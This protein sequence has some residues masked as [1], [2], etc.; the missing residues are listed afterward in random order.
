MTGTG[1]REQK[2][3]ER[4]EAVWAV[5]FYGSPGETPW[6][7]PSL[8]L[9]HPAVGETVTYPN[10]TKA[11]KNENSQPLVPIRL[12]PAGAQQTPRCRSLPT[13]IPAQSLVRLLRAPLLFQ[14]QPVRPFFFCVFSSSSSFVFHKASR[15]KAAS[16][17][18]TLLCTPP[19]RLASSLRKTFCFSS[20]LHS[21]MSFSGPVVAGVGLGCALVAAVIATFAVFAI[22]RDH[23]QGYIDRLLDRHRSDDGDGD[24]ISA[25]DSGE[26]ALVVAQIG[27]IYR[28]VWPLETELSRRYNSFRVALD[29]VVGHYRFSHKLD[30]P[31]TS[32]FDAVAGPHPDWE[33]FLEDDYTHRQ[34]PA[35]QHLICRILHQRMIPEGDPATTLLPPDIMSVYKK[36]MARDPRSFSATTYGSASNPRLE[37]LGRVMRHVWRGLTCHFAAYHA[38]HIIPENGL[39]D[40]DERMENVLATEKLLREEVLVHFRLST[41]KSRGQRDEELRNLMFFA[42]ELAFLAFSSAEPIEL[43]WPRSGRPETD[44]ANNDELVLTCFG[45]RMRNRIPGAERLSERETSELTWYVMQEPED[46]ET[47]K[48]IYERDNRRAWQEQDRAEAR[49]ANVAYNA[50]DRLVPARASN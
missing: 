2:G 24:G 18:P 45:I 4:L 16:P 37:N 36:M 33:I 12:S 41:D 6:P 21:N 26:A 3:Q 38:P 7:V 17:S 35:A 43:F 10:V 11:S 22:A 23:F 47:A 46:N 42:A 5:S 19:P 49:L 34:R 27:R 39:A 15:K 25:M 9:P 29:R 50:L 1:K 32:V 30:L 44:A 48:R 13:C 31:D 8:I 28:S 20:A 14:Y 40:D